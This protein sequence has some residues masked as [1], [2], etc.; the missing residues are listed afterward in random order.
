[1]LNWTLT[2][3]VTAFIKMSGF[4]G[5]GRRLYHNTP[6]EL[7]EPGLCPSVYLNVLP[8][9][10]NSAPAMAAFEFS[11]NFPACEAQ[12]GCSWRSFGFVNRPGVLLH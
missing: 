12:A 7:G 3:L 9:R 4:K 6:G 8:N 1:M 11:R 10:N 5:K 2:K